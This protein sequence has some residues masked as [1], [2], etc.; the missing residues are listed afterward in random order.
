[1]FEIAVFWFTCFLYFKIISSF[2]FSVSLSIIA[3]LLISICSVFIVVAIGVFLSPKIQQ[4]SA[5]IVVAPIDREKVGEM[6]LRW[7]APPIVAF[8]LVNTALGYLISHGFSER[9]LES[10]FEQAPYDKRGW[11]PAVQ[12]A[13]LFGGPALFFYL[14]QAFR[15]YKGIVQYLEMK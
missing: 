5:K 7:F 4:E 12:L 6:I 2:M 3:A 13:F 11:L 8:I 1:M 14:P 10:A 9:F 15:T